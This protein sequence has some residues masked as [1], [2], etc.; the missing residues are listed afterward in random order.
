MNFA[1]SARAAEGKTGWKE[2]V[3][4]SMVPQRPHKAM[5]ETR[6]YERLKARLGGK[7]LLNHLWCP[8]D[9][10]RLWERLDYMK[11]FQCS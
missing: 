2:I 1:S 6:L 7:R 3:K 5:G 11:D 9:L 4:S 8:N 10:T